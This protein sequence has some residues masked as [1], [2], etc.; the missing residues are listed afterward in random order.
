MQPDAQESESHDIGGWK[1]HLG[2]WGAYAAA[3]GTAMAM[4]TNASAASII[5]ST[6]DFTVSISP[7]QV[8]GPLSV[9]GVRAAL[10][11]QR[12]TQ[13]PR[14]IGRASL[15]GVGTSSAGPNS[16]LPH[17]NFKGIGGRQA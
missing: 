3:A 6:P 9:G 7:G 2:N 12:Y 1:Q 15:F 11:V 5:S 10:T 14:L 4:S 17:L 13:G 8:R 16:N